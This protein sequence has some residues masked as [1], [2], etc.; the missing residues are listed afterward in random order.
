MTLYTAT[1][2]LILVMDPLGNIPFFVSALKGYEP[3][4]QKIIILREMA[5]AYIT[6]LLFLFF[7]GKILQ[8]LHIT[9]AA[10]QIAGGMIL[11]LI[12][13]PM[14]FPSMHSGGEEIHGEPFIVPLAI[15]LTAGPST[16]ATVL[17]FTTHQSSDLFILFLAITIA[18][19]LFLLTMLFSNVFIRILGKR[20]LI[21]M[22]RLMGLLLSTIAVQMFLEGLKAF[23]RT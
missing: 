5:I 21:A 11:F 1:L 16:M 12:T 17:L 10:L 7:G 13:L 19:L 15:P 3:R 2:I 8:N 14:V 6:L 23:L 18:T 9:P 22:E 20:G 4:R